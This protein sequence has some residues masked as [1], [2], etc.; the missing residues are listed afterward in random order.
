MFIF[1]PVALGIYA[2][3]PRLRRTDLLPMISS[4]FFVCVNIHDLL[5][6]IY[7]VG[8][9]ISSAVA[10]KIYK[11]TKK[12]TCLVT[13]EIL[14]LVSAVVSLLY[15]FIFTSEAVYHAG[16]LVCLIAVI[17]MCSDILN[18]QGRA[19]DTVW[20][21]LVYITF[22][23]I[24]LAGPFV[25]Y[26]DFIEKLDNVQFSA[27]NFLKGVIR[28]ILG[29]IKC[30]AISAVLGRV[31][32]ET[33]ALEGSFGL[34]VYL[35]MAAICGVRIY[36]F[37]S[38]YSDMGRGIALML[39]VDLKKDF[40]DPFLNP[41]PADYIK[42]FFRSLSEF[43]KLYIVT[44]TDRL[45][46]YKRSGKLVACIFAGCYYVFLMC[47][48]PETALL[49]FLPVAF[50]A[51]FVMFRPKEKRLNLPLGLKIPCAVITFALISLVWM[52]I[53]LGDVS[54]LSVAVKNI[55]ENPIDYSSSEVKAILISNKYIAVPIVAAAAVLVIS[56][57]LSVESEESDADFSV[58]VFVARASA[59][60]ILAVLFIIT[61]IF[62]LPQFPDIVS[63]ANVFYFI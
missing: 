23:P 13:L 9:A 38:G 34:C 7:Y 42:R 49:L 37:F 4:V 43:C 1:L 47:K 39:G 58:R 44:P 53:S 27:D 15:R 14:A 57:V 35:F 54:A 16:L 8:V 30:V 41:T 20:E 12:R 48:T 10:L 17:S 2:M 18:N 25:R 6:L 5:S 63:Y 59:M 21:A 33:M 61:V 22:F 31:Y 55:I 45:F 36:T 56:K 3:T 62:I 24:M 28:F 11:R 51:Y 32:D 46:G 40:K 60:T 19:P 50:V 26:G 29:F 52:I